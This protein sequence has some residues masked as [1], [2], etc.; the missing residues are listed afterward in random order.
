M[1]T[2]RSAGQSSASSASSC[3]LLK[4]SNGV[5]VA[6]AASSGVACAVMLFSVSMVNVI[7]NLLCSALLAVITSITRNCLKRKAIV[8]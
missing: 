7:V 4:L 5:A 2:R 8:L 3:W 1:A 6:A